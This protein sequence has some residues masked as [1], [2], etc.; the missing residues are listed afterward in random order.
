MIVCDPQGKRL[1]RLEKNGQAVTLVREFEGKAFYGPNDLVLDGSGN[2][3][4][5]DPAGWDRSKQP[6][7]G[8]YRLTPGG[9]ITL[10]A[11][12]IPT[13]NG[14]AL[15]PDETTLLVASTHGQCIRELK[16][17]RH[18]RVASRRVFAPLEQVPGGPDGM[19]LDEKGNLYVAVFGAG[20]VTVVDTS[21]KIVRRLDVGGKNPTNCCFGGSDF[22]TLYVTETQ[23]NRVV[24]LRLDVA[25]QRP[26]HVHKHPTSRPQQ[27]R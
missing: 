23:Y 27:S 8:V 3:Y 2:I 9:T 18:G 10:L 12:D 4:F 13:P 14:I 21:G 1:V 26:L 20:C 5:T 11:G 7:G 22:K 17:D 15:R 24:A 6:K 19:A 16:L 25:G